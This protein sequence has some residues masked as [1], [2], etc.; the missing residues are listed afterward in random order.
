M[1]L[2]SN[3][4]FTEEQY[5]LLYLVKLILNQEHDISLNLTLPEDPTILECERTKKYLDFFFQYLF[6]KDLEDNRKEE[7]ICIPF[8]QGKK[9]LLIV[10]RKNTLGFSGHLK[11]V[12]SLAVKFCG[13]I[14][15]EVQVLVEEEMLQQKKRNE[16]MHY[17]R[18]KIK[19]W[20]I[21]LKQRQEFYDKRE[22]FKLYWN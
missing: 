11:G 6:I 10:E 17:L 1:K 2:D 8:A 18:T 22:D 7:G 21:D 9:V 13:Y 20:Q 15:D 14:Y 5:Q 19:S 4:T 3:L 12:A 16:K